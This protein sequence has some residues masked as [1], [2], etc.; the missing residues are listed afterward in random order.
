[1]RMGRSGVT[2][3]AA[4]TYCSE[5]VLVV[6]HFHAPAAQDIGRPDH[7]RIADPGRH[8]QGLLQV[9]GHARLRHGDAQLA[10]HLTETV[11]V[12]GQVDGIRG[13]AQD[14]DA[15]LGQFIWRY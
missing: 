8:R 4:A 12:L 13:G 5:H 10:H 2:P 9:A 3:T 14:F 1:M 7:E 15:G 6:D 11:P